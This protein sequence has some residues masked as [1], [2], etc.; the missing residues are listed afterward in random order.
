MLYPL[1]KFS[2]VFSFLT[3]EH[4]M[5][6]LP[7]GS[8]TLFLRQTGTAK[9][10]NSSGHSVQSQTTAELSAEIPSSSTAE[11]ETATGFSHS[12]FPS[13]DV[14]ITSQVARGGVQ[15]SIR[16]WT[17]FPTGT[18]TNLSRAVPYRIIAVII[19]T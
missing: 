5:R 2:F 11:A 4:M 6:I 9:P 17:Y 8:A 14:F 13:V 16:R 19:C 3:T 15:G 18:C 10:S 7:S 1:Y 12:P